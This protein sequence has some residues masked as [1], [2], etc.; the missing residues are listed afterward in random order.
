M[1]TAAIVTNKAIQEKDDKC[2]IYYSN[3]ARVYRNI[4]DFERV[5]TTLFR[6]IKMLKKLFLWMKKI[7]K[8]TI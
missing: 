8:A 4:E 2:S 1:Y 3:R 7:S 6:A 5:K